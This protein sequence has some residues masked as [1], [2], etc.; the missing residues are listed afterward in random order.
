L[1]IL[2]SGNGSE[3]GIKEQFFKVVVRPSHLLDSACDAALVQLYMVGIS[4]QKK[5]LYGFFDII[6][7]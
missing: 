5:A 6:L 2:L 1:R 4:G 7:P 3:L